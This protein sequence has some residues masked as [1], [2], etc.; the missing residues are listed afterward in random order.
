MPVKKSE[1]VQEIPLS[2]LHPFKNHPFRV[3]DDEAMQRTVKPCVPQHRD[4][5]GSNVMAAKAERNTW[6][7]QGANLNA[8]KNGQSAAKPRTEGRSTTILC[9]SRVKR[10]EVV[11]PAISG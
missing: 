7:A 3:V 4:E 9:R 1:R 8:G 2:E 10:P 6:I 11:C 5:T